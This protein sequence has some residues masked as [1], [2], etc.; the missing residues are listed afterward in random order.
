MA[1]D[2]KTV[3]AFDLYG[4]LLSTDSIAKELSSHFGDEKAKALAALWR[5]YQL[6]YTWRL[7][8]M[9][10][11]KDFSAVTRASLAHALAESSLSLPPA[12]I[13]SLMGAYDSLD[14]NP[15]AGPGLASLQSSTGIDAYIFSNGSPSMLT[16]SV[17][18]SPSMAQFQGVFQAIVSVEDVKVFKPD[19]KAYHHLAGR[20][21]RGDL[22]SIWLVSSNPF[23]IVGARAAGLKAAWVD[24]A[25]LGWI[26]GLGDLVGGKGPTVVVKGVDEAVREIRRQVGDL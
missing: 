10:I 18:K 26:D 8:S 7:N 17:T 16:A 2:K 23:D 5:R 21:G 6:E 14:L 11:Y 12:A 19:P 24:R 4:T 3:I 9:S 22:E 13:D 1:P 15:D 25:G 20:V